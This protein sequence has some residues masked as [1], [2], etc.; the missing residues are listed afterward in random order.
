MT[1]KVAV[2]TGSAHGIGLALTKTC[3]QQHMHVVMADRNQPTLLA[4]AKLLGDAVSPIACDVSNPADLQTLANFCN[5]TFGRVDLLI[6]NAGIM[7]EIKPVWQ[8]DI[9]ALQQ[10]LDINVY[11]VLHGIQ[12][13]MPYLLQQEHPSH[14]VNMSSMLGLFSTSHIAPYILSKN[15]VVALSEALYF[16]LQQIKASIDV[17]VVCPS[18]VNTNLLAHSPLAE[19]ASRINK[20]QQWMQY[21]SETLDVANDIMHGIANKLFYILPDRSIKNDVD[22]RLQAVL[23]QKAPY[24]HR[25]Q[26]L[27]NTT[28]TAPQNN[29]PD[30][31][32]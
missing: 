12:A 17:S 22:A 18:F 2:I 9:T 16:D 6:N 7:G 5:K 19:S 8:L 13:F 10:V 1:M 29:D 11:G 31:L 21:G 24:E 28:A 20:M 32:L 4:E 3:V 27:F 23:A 14:I 15:A 30:A 26:K 25:W